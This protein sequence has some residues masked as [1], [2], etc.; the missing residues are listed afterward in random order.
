[1]LNMRIP[2]KIVNLT[3]VT[4]TVSAKVII[5]NLCIK[6]IN[7]SCEVRQRCGLSALLFNISLQEVMQVL[8]NIGI[9]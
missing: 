5:G 4:L 3:A 8:K 9:I 2:K 7:I 1:M 6:H